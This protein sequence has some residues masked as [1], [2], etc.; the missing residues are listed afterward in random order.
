M[1]HY[2]MPTS[3]TR[4]SKPKRDRTNENFLKCTNSLLEKSNNLTRY[5]ADVYLLI[6]RRGKLWEYKSLHCD[7]WPLPSRAIVNT[8]A[9]ESNSAYSLL[10]KI[11]TL[12]R[13]RKRRMITLRKGRLGWIWLYVLWIVNDIHTYKRGSFRV[14]T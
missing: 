12:Y 2:V 3:S 14:D 5:Q 4:I 6:R 1:F 11:I 7:C 13:P 8:T 9:T 10:R